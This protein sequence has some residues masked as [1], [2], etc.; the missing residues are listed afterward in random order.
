MKILFG[1]IAI[2]GL[3]AGVMH[4]AGSRRARRGSPVLPT[5]DAAIAEQVRAGLGASSGID[6]RVR[7]GIVALR[8][9]ASP[10]ERDRMLTHALSIPGVQRVYSDLDS[11]ASILQTGAA[12]AGIVH[13]N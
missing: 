4:F 12:K 1:L 6:V 5:A 3:A 2:A 10:E 11:D 8:G 13:S 9:T 7:N